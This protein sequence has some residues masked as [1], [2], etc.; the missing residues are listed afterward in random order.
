MTVLLAL[1]CGAGFESLQIAKSCLQDG[2][3]EPLPSSDVYAF[4]VLLLATVGCQQPEQQIELQRSTAYL[5]ELQHDL[6]DPTQVPGQRKHLEWLRDLLVDPT[7]PDYAELVSDPAKVLFACIHCRLQSSTQFA[8]PVYSS[9]ETV[10]DDWEI[11][12]LI[13]HLLFIAFHDRA[14][15]LMQ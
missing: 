9:P 6:W 11:T 1:K 2:G 12:T 8:C 3:Y 4:G 14:P 7:K 10:E 15:R 13:K 5:T